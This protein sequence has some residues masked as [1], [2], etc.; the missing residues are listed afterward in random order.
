MLNFFGRKNIKYVYNK[1]TYL[2]YPNFFTIHRLL[3]PRLKTEGGDAFSV[4][5][6]G[7]YQKSLYRRQKNG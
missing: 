1:T 6:N 3:H 5:K 4:A 2:K 7:S